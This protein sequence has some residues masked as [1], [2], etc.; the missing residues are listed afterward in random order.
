MS[1]RLADERLK[2][3]FNRWRIWSERLALF[4]RGLES[5]IVPFLNILAVAYLIFGLDDL[6]IDINAYVR[7]LFPQRATPTELEELYR[8]PEKRIAIIIP[9]WHES[10]IIARM[11]AGNFERIEYAAYDFFIGVYPNDEETIEAVRQAQGICPNV[12][13]V[14]NEKAGPTTKGQMLNLVVRSIFEFEKINQVHFDA[15]HMQDAEDIIH[16]LALM[17]VN[18]RLD[19]FDFIQIPVF[20]LEVKAL[21]LVGGTY[22]DEFAESH[23]KDMFVREALG[24]AIPSAGVGTTMSRRLILALMNKQGGDYLNEG[25]LTED[26][27]LGQQAKNLGY[28]SHFA[29][30]TYLEPET[31][32]LEFIATREY[33]PKGFHR[34]IRQKTR[35]V[36]GISFQGWANLGWPG[37]WA[38][39][40][41]L[42]RDRKSPL[43]NLLSLLGY[44]CLPL[45][46]YLKSQPSE[47]DANPPPQI[48]LWLITANLLL[49]FNRFLQR[50]IC[51]YRVYGPKALPAIVLRLP[52]A[53]V[54]NAFASYYAFKKVMTAKLEKRE[55]LKWDST[56]HEIPEGFGQLTVKTA[57]PSAKEPV[58]AGD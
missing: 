19:S 2:R 15:I 46:F 9:A 4:L 38:N 6:F 36:T 37:S 16:P 39:R 57:Q 13:C 56:D 55:R 30:V 29:C 8:L 22:M 7:R 21:Q 10:E 23:T 17:L 51:V 32:A 40:Y 41:F 1:I 18:Q 27:E 47:D 5:V 48:P 26:Y 25:S 50:C 12:H 11:L 42:W 20:S 34:S 24:A 54:I 35:W 28:A 44:L 31:G 3:P 14:I 53:N 33:F 45:L 58:F 43:A 52:L 49:M